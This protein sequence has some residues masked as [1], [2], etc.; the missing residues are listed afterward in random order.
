MTLFEEYFMKPLPLLAAMAAALLSACGGSDSGPAPANPQPLSVSN[1]TVQVNLGDAPADRLLAVN[2]NVSSLALTNAAGGTVSVLGA[3]RSVEVMQLMG[4]VTPLAL[5]DVPQGS[6]TGAT[7]TFGQASVTHLDAGTGQIVQRTAPGPMTARIAFDPPLAVGAAPMVLNLDMHMASSVAIDASGNV[8]VTPTLTATARPMLAGSRHPEDGGMQ[9]LIATVGAV[10]GGAFTAS[11]AQGLGAASMTTHAGTHYSGLAGTHMMAGNM[12]VSVDAVPQLGG[13]WRVD[14][15]QSRMAAGGSMAGGLIT[16]VVGSPPTGLTVVMHEGAGN[17]MV[18]GDLAGIATIGLGG[19]TQFAI[20]A[21][22]VDLTG[23]PFSPQFDRTHLS[24]GQAVRAW[25][26]AP[27][28]HHGGGGMAAGRTV[29]AARV[30]LKPQGLRGTV[31]GYA[32]NGAQSSFTLT[33]PADAAFARLAG[34]TT[35]TVYQQAGTQLRGLS[36]LTNGST[37]QVRGLLFRDGNAFR[38]VA[39]RIVAA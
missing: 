4:T 1:T 28:G 14:H 22:S 25:S 10:Q 6:Y 23:L 31:S 16:E 20:D 24:R 26:S 35:V 8:S 15:V 36:S 29:D 32:S 18:G 30:E 11:M 12:L 17:G 34:A 27:I 3:A 13:A 38:L 7:M 5:A 21:D 37:V 2:M 33:L 39:S 9:G 19:G